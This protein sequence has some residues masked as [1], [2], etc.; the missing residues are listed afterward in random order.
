MSSSFVQILLRVVTL[1]LES[2]LCLPIRQNLPYTI[3]NHGH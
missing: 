3:V 2:G 1:K